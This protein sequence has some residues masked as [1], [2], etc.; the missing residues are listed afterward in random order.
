MGKGGKGGK[1]T[2]ASDVCSIDLLRKKQYKTPNNCF[3]RRKKR[4]LQ[5][6][7]LVKGA[8]QRAQPKKVRRKAEKKVIVRPKYN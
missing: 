2:Q 8:K 4:H 5:H 1:S 3:C 7:P 6:Q